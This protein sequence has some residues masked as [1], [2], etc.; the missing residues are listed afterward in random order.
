MKIK[1]I[2]TACFLTIL[3][4]SCEK[5]ILIIP[6]QSSLTLPLYFKTQADFESAVN[7]IYKSMTSWFSSSNH[8][9]NNI[10]IGDMHSDNSRYYHNRDFYSPEYLVEITKS[11]DF[12][13]DNQVFSAYWNDFYKWISLANQVLDL[14]DDATFDNVIKDNLKGQALF[15]RA[16]SYW[17]L[18]RLYGDACIHLKPV[19][20]VEEASVSLSPQT[21]IIAQVISDATLASTLLKNKA[22]QEAG[23]VT[24]GAAKMLL[25]DVYMWQKE[26]S[27]AETQ[28]MSLKNEYS[29]MP[30]YTDVT[31]PVK[32]NNAESI[33]EIQYSSVLSAFANSVVYSMFPFPFSAD[34]LKAMT[35]ISNPQSLTK[36]VGLA[37]PTPELIALYEPGDKRFAASIKYVHDIDGVVIPMCIKYLHAHNLINQSN[38]NMPVYRYAETLLFLAEA[39]NEQ[40]GR[41]GEAL[42]YLNQVRNRAGLDNTTASTQ[43]EIRDAVLK[44]RQIELAFEG[45]RWF[46]LVR[47]GKAIEVITAY[48]ARVI[49]NPQNYYF[50]GA[51][52]FPTAF[53]GFT[54][55][56]N[57]PTGERLYNQKI[58]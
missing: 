9:A 12:V 16:Y 43:S 56:F 28:L 10:I 40:G 34:S 46:D 54:T 25:G 18:A 20:S 37:I 1:Y 44:E 39:I 32:K 58:D 47:T 51:S 13:P 50:V 41:T 6:S 3:T 15:I 36:G 48:G 29:L 33:F 45:K 14:I 31:D 27:N 7:G 8:Y 2:M 26:W 23:R 57:I 55:K 53:T 35:G 52:P 24:S 5:D 22:T 49:A 21:D 17:W 42:E 4:T 11:A 38:E 19:A 30:N